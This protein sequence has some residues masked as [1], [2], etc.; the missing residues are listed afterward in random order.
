MAITTRIAPLYGGQKIFAALLCAV[1][2]VWGAYDYF[3]KIPNQEKI[4]AEYAEITERLRKLDGKTVTGEE[5]R[6]VQADTQRLQ[7]ISP[8]NAP[9][10]APSKFDRVTQWFFMASFPF[11]PLFFWMFIKAKR[12]SY[13]LDDDGALHFTG[14]P[15]LKSGMWDHAQITDIDMERWMAK[16]IAY[17]V[18]SDGTRL[19]LDAYLHKDLHLIVGALASR[20]YPEKWDPQA[21]MIKPAE[22]QAADSGDESDDDALST[23]PAT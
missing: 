16:S 7:E 19:K 18:H 12:Q 21:K 11:A 3:I 9:P 1:F 22:E 8:N 15:Q 23:T 13:T 20:F 17:A 5:L 4:V 14:D 6:R 10:V 2:G